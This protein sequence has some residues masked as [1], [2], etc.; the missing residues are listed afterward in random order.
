MS[1]F[2][3]DNICMDCNEV[4]NN[5]SDIKFAKEIEKLYVDAGDIKYPGVGWPGENGRIDRSLFE[6]LTI[7][8]IKAARLANM[9]EE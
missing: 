2:N 8:T 6:G 3:T 5:H 9:E 1:W 7:E 4:E